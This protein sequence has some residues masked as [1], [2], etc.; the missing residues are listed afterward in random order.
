MKV[1]LSRE[2]VIAALEKHV[3]GMFTGMKVSYD[4]D[5]YRDSRAWNFDILP[6]EP[7]APIADEI[8]P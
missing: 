6:K 2:E 8:T 3:S 4:D 7:P 1:E 5:C